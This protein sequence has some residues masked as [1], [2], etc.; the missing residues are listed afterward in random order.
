MMSDYEHESDYYMIRSHVVILTLFTLIFVA[1]ISPS[2]AQSTTSSEKSKQITET[3]TQFAQIDTERSSAKIGTKDRIDAA[4][5]A[6]NLA[7]G[8]AWAYF[9]E[10]QYD[11]A[12]IWF[13]KRADL[14]NDVYKSNMA[15]IDEN[16]NKTID[17]TN[18]K[19]A[20]AP[21]N[22]KKI[23]LSMLFSL[24]LYR[25]SSL[26][27]VA[28]NWN[29]QQKLLEITR[30]ELNIKQQQLDNLKADK[31]SQDKIYDAIVGIADC[32]GSIGGA[33]ES[34]AQ[35]DQ[36]EKFYREALDIRK[37]LPNTV[38][39]KGLHESLSDLGRLYSDMG[40][41]AKAL[42]YYQQAVDA[43]HANA[44]Q[45]RKAVE[46]EGT[47]QLKN[48]LHITQLV[49]E[50]TILNNV[51][52]VYGNM[53]DY[54]KNLS[55]VEQA[56]KIIDT[57]PSGDVGN[58]ARSKMHAIALGNIAEIH[59]DNGQT[60]LAL[61]EFQDVL[62]QYK[63]L[64]DDEGTAVILSNMAGI[65]AEKGDY[66]KA[67]RDTVLARQILISKQNLN[68]VILTDLHIASLNRKLE[69]IAESEDYTNQ[70]LILARKTGNL[71]LTASS[72]RTLASIRI[73]QNALKDAKTLLDDAESIDKKVDS[74]FDTEDT[75]N[76]QGLLLEAEGKPQ[77][78]LEKYK[79]AIA[80]LESVR[81]KTTSTE[82]DFGSLY[83]NY[84]P[85]EHIVKLLIKMGRNEDAFN[86]LS[87]AKSKQLI[88]TLTVSSIKTGDKELQSLLDRAGKLQE[89]L[90]AVQ[91]KLQAEQAKP[92]GQRDETT[93]KNLQAIA[94][95][96]QGEYYDLADTIKEK[97]PD[98]D[99][100]MTVKPTEL[101][102][103]QDA[104]PSDA[105]LI[106]YAPLGDQLYIF[107]VTNTSVKIV[108][109]QVKPDDLWRKIEEIRKL[110][111]I[112]GEQTERGMIRA[113]TRPVNIA[114][115]LSLSEQLISGYD[116]LIAPIEKDIADK[117]IL[118]FVPTHQLYYLPMQALA[119]KTPTGLRY[120]VQDKQI[121]YLAA[122]DVLS[123][124]QQKRGALGI[125]MTAFGDPT[126]AGLPYAGEE[127]N[128]I[129]QVYTGT[130]VL[131]GDKATK[132]AFNNPENWNKRIIHLAT[133]G[134]LNPNVPRKS[135]IQLALGKA[136]EDSELTVGEIYGLP[137]SKID[138]V[139]I[140]AC[141]TAL[142]EQNPGSEI[143]S[144]ATA[145][146]RAKARTVVASLWS[147]ADDSTK[148]F[149]VEFYKQLTSG[150]SK[151]AALQ[152]AQIKVMQ[153]PKYKY[154]YYWAPFIMMGDW[155]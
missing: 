58:Y 117:Q 84:I 73:K 112:P 68:K 19:L 9:D 59:A 146:S 85:Y 53:G 47:E 7:L 8:I 105:I 69:H 108:T 104:I 70:A 62:N 86:Y 97:Y 101:A 13:A 126:G 43:L 52:I 65:Y 150:K 153:N 15:F 2:F 142:G 10:K 78:A 103:A 88:D 60:D 107:V 145:F 44:E 121:A 11:N 144:L 29:D 76:L 143:L 133:H 55:Y 119:R 77:D 115:K 87:R 155:R 41:Y 48:V 50:A 42:D 128:A 57:I 54:Q 118:L 122:A 136:P 127:V 71:D 151:A 64:G 40:E 111:S 3:Q 99:Q 74:P 92:E 106:E 139:T 67:L 14:E 102:G 124:I 27:M 83:N 120:L 79:S 130:D 6:S 21:Q 34:L 18:D 33:L 81:S 36:A 90:Q 28:R 39:S 72:E 141:E 149:M 147:V 109:T 45:R 135:Y 154:P 96:T 94:T 66:E 148:E 123:V 37:S 1:I 32:K 89:K 114:D 75:Y 91:S 129:S 22:T 80:I 134:I 125:G 100:I 95:K 116:M 49:T 61:Q 113:H 56:S 82:S 63:A 51:G 20:T 16:C 131:L 140:S 98:Y 35:Y 25:V 17:Q 31:E 23:I 138:L 38:L 137:L 24:R 26:E 132:S 152:A 4:T 12:A 30:E 110:I 5:K 93:V 46:A